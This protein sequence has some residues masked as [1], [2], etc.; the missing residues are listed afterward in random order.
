M[1]SGGSRPFARKKHMC[2]RGRGANPTCFSPLFLPGGVAF[3]WLDCLMM[4]REPAWPNSIIGFT[5]VHLSTS[6]RKD[7]GGPQEAKIWGRFPE[8][9]PVRGYLKRC[10]LAV[11]QNW[12]R[13]VTWT[14]TCGPLVPECFLFA[15][16]PL[17]PSLVGQVNSHLPAV[18]GFCWHRRYQEPGPKRIGG[19]PLHREQ[20]ATDCAEP[21]TA[22]RRWIC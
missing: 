19:G 20:H 9:P 1:K 4:S 10:H 8:K 13:T 5:S 2:L 22:L 14:K 17:E 12:Y 16:H 18:P 7:K 6:P 11:G 3:V 21:L 15:P